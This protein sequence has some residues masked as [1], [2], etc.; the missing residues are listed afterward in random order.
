VSPQPWAIAGST[1]TYADPWLRVRS[2]RCVT[3]DGRVVEPVHVL[4]FPD[5][6]NVVALTADHEIVLVREY[7]HGAGQVL[8]GLPT[9][10][11]DPDDPDPET[12]ARRELREETGFTG[13]TFHELS[14]LYANPAN[15]NNL[16]WSYLAIGVRRTETPRLEAHE[17][18]EVIVEDAGSFYRRFWRHEAPLQVSHAAAVMAAGQLILTGRFPGLDRLC[19]SIR[20]G[21]FGGE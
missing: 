7:R 15:Q 10:T 21:L 4:E 20:S 3:A 14:S 17:E 18:I 8:T 9:G 19:E 2:D 12:A 5:W 6:D 13:G 11:M 1:I 16:V